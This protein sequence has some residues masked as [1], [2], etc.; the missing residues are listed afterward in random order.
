MRTAAGPATSWAPVP[1]EPAPD[2]ATR[3]AASS[4]RA[5][6]VILFESSL[7]FGHLA[8]VGGFTASAFARPGGV[9]FTP[10][11]FFSAG[12]ALVFFV[13]SK[14]PFCRSRI[15]AYCAARG[16]RW[17]RSKET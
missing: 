10:S 8:T 1:P 6:S 4:S 9:A 16:A 12:F 13:I 17:Q 2:F 7:G 3:P 11:V 15:A 5:R 14:S